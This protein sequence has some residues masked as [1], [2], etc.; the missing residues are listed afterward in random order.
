M[1][2]P[3]VLWWAILLLS[4]PAFAQNPE[5]GITEETWNLLVRAKW[6]AGPTPLDKIADPRAAIAIGWRRVLTGELTP[7][8]FY[9]E[10]ARVDLGG[11]QLREALVDTKTRLIE[12]LG[13]REASHFLGEIYTPD[14]STP[15]GGPGSA[16]EDRILDWRRQ[17]STRNGERAM[18]TLA[19]ELRADAGRYS[20]FLCDIGSRP[21][22]PG[23]EAFAGDIDVNLITSHPGIFRR[24]LEIW[25]DGIREATGGLKGTDVDIVAT[26]LGMSGPEVYPG[27][28]GR[29]KAV[30]FILSGKAGNVRRVDLATGRVGE[31]VDGRLALA[32]VGFQG[33]LAGIEID[34]TGAFK[35]PESGP[36]L[37]LDM[38]R[39]LERDVLRHMQFEDLDTF[40]KVAKFVERASAEAAAAGHPLDEGT[41]RLSR[42]LLEAKQAGDYVRATEIVKNHFG[43]L[44]VDVRLGRSVEGKSPLT[45]EAN[46]RFIEQFS[47]GCFTDLMTAGKAALGDEIKTLR[48]RIRLLEAGMED[49]REVAR[50]FA[51]LRNDMEMEK[52]VLEHPAEGL[53][54]M[55]PEVVRLVEDLRTTNQTF[56]KD[57]WEKVLPEHLRRQR[58]FVEEM[59]KSGSESGRELA[60]AALTHRSP[61][62]QGLEAV[63]AVNTL[64]D[65]FDNTLLGPLRGEV[66]WRAELFAARQLGYAARARAFF[67]IELPADVGRYLSEMEAGHRSFE[68]KLNSRLFDNFLARRIQE[69]NRLFGKS[70]GDSSVG[71]AMLKGLQVIKLADELPQYWDAFDKPTLAEGLQD[72]AG[73][74]IENRVPLASTA[75]H[76]LAG[77]M[78]LAALDLFST[79]L[80]PAA[81]AQTVFGFG[82]AL[83]RRALHFYWSARLEAFADELYAGATWELAG[84]HQAGQA[85]RIED[86]KLVSVSHREKRI[87]LDDYIREKEGQIAEMRAA[88]R[89]PYK[90]RR[91]PYEHAGADPFLGWTG[92]DD[93][94]RENLARADNVLLLYEEWRKNPLAGWK[95]QD[96]VHQRWTLRWEMVKVAWLKKLIRQL[97][98]RRANRG[99]GFARL[100]ELL[101]ELDAVTERLKVREHVREALEQ[102]I[103]SSEVLRALRWW[104][105]RNERERREGLELPDLEDAYEKGARIAARYLDVYDT[106]LAARTDAEERF[107]GE[108]YPAED[109]GLR[110][111]STPFLLACRADADEGAYAAQRSLPEAIRTVT[112][113]ELLQ[114]K[115]LLAGG[116]L[117]SADASVDQRTLHGM[118][119]HEVFRELWRKVELATAR[120][121][122]DVTNLDPRLLREL[123]LDAAFGNDERVRAAAGDA[124]DRAAGTEEL[125]GIGARDLPMERFRAH[126]AERRRLLGDF[127]RHYVQSGRLAGLRRR[128]EEIAAELARRR[129][130]AAADLEATGA[131]Q[132]EARAEDLAATLDALSPR[133]EEIPALVAAIAA[134]HEE[135]RQAA[136]ALGAGVPRIETMAE[137]IC[138]GL[139]AA[140]GEADPARRSERLAAMRT[141]STELDAEEGRA[142]TQGRSV[143]E[144]AEEAQTAWASLEAI[145]EELRRL[146]ETA[147]GDKSEEA[148]GQSEGA[149]TAPLLAELDG[150]VPEAEEAAADAVA[151]AG[152]LPKG[153]ETAGLSAQIEAARDGIKKV[154]AQA[155][156]AQQKMA[157]ALAEAQAEF[158]A[159]AAA[160]QAAR[161]RLAEARRQLEARRAEIEQAYGD[162]ES[163]DLMAGLAGNA[164]ERIATACAGAGLCTDL[165][166]QLMNHGTVPDLAGRTLAEAQALLKGAGLNA[167]PR[168]GRA[169]SA[170]EL[171][172][173]VAAQE[174]AAGSA[175]PEN[176]TVTLEV[177][178]PA[179]VAAVPAVI[180]RPAAEARTAIEQAGF[181]PTLAAGD[182]A[183]DPEAQFRVQAQDPPAGSRAQPGDPVVLHIYGAFDPAAATAGVDCSVWPGTVP[184]WHDAGAR[185]ECPGGSTWESGRCTAAP[186][187][188][189]APG[190]S[191][192]E[193]SAPDRCEELSSA[194]WGA[195]TDRRLDEARD[196]L[197]RSRDCEFYNRGAAAVQSELDLACRRLDLQIR[198]AC[199]ARDLPAA[200]GLVAE[201]QAR[202][203]TISPEALAAIRNVEQANRQQQWGQLFGAMNDIIRIQQEQRNASRSGSVPAPRAPVVQNPTIPPIQVPRN[204]TP[205]VREP[206]PGAATPTTGGATGRSR[207]ECERQYCPMCFNDV[208]L[209]SVS[210]DPQCNQCRK[211]RATNIEACMAGGAGG[212]GAAL[213]GTYR[214]VCHRPESPLPG[215]ANGCSS[216]SCLG[217]RDVKRAQDTVVGQ[218]NSWD[219]CKATSD[220]YNS[221]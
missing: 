8:E 162:A 74:F 210:V 18:Q 9:R 109:H 16:V 42:E 90:E 130:A 11:M 61:L 40:M 170:P 34:E 205:A 10:M 152:R 188:A 149:E 153:E 12:T 201:A 20:A 27:E 175:L 206:A 121:Q 119:Y 55:D 129:A 212:T 159:A 33:G 165:A 126:E 202:Q 58:K 197:S 98:G 24:F 112:H 3:K 132:L 80:P 26:V 14:L 204:T 213:T 63:D 215:Q 216:Y 133:L 104:R 23:A 37:I 99:A 179:A 191:V 32:E 59:L 68:T 102:E 220:N 2:F 25:D 180:G 161:Q 144:A 122:G 185:C 160:L 75:G 157:A 139:A 183:P 94:L 45:I 100:T 176:R 136:T 1:R 148:P 60:A 77:N 135:A 190:A 7:Q 64:L 43:E 70:V 181:T 108:G 150:I 145:E 147:A 200:Q 56:L 158:R 192:P 111:L 28:P 118:T 13:T 189:S 142:R 49:P 81:M 166:G 173:T 76:V 67:G 156:A 141:R 69:A 134:A 194:F 57:H 4:A 196:T 151:A 30:D 65:T 116:G 105:D 184:V 92:E 15:G 125:E 208:D 97:E 182:P 218:Y 83:G 88:L 48:G 84:S 46:R 207:S 66:D 44:P 19:R 6:S 21:S 219:A 17:L 71:S 95:L 52:L 101:L 51:R 168:A 93:M 117:E 174:P 199:I 110:L 96:D 35:L 198:Q 155:H 177:Y 193:A 115:A 62:Q 79:V 47:R 31:T 39:H 128:A 85:A 146:E 214:L 22:G 120:L 167:A 211:V 36:A 209:L 73:K 217:P 138:R 106:V 171:E 53:R 86:W 203:C 54:Q 29:I 103:G 195:M 127:I 87:V 114:I 124:L 172:Y 169:A 154:A 78:T 143:A 123:A 82:E 50:D 5:A 178:G 89:V 113:D 131:R 163:A 72:L 221:N 91:F 41:V 137:E 186:L 187:L 107:T 140:R 164:L 38:A